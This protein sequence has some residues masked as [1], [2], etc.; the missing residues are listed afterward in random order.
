MREINALCQ[1]ETGPSPRSHGI[2]IPGD[3]TLRI[4]INPHR[5]S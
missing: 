2:V 4:E 3:Q 1:R 5:L